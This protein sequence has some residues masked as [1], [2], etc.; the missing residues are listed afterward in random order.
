[1]ARQRYDD[2]LRQAEQ[3][4]LARLVLQGR[5]QRDGPTGDE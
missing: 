3:E 2:L 5:H 4:R 1:M